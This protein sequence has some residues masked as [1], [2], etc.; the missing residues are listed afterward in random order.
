M[1]LFI[2]ATKVSTNLTEDLSEREALGEKWLNEIKTKC[3]DA[4]FLH[5]WALLGPYDFIDVFEAPDHETALKVSLLTKSAGAT[6][7]ETWTAIAYKH[8]LKLTQE[9]S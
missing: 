2:L 8:F 6:F 7:A 3:P 1:P 9:I 5:H 4:K